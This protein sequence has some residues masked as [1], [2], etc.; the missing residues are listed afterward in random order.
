MI[1][2]EKRKTIYSLYQEGMQLAEISRRLRVS[3]NT[4]RAIVKQSGR[5]PNLPRKDKVKIDEELLR[6]LH[7]KCG[8]WLQRIHEKLVEEEG[9]QIGYSTLTRMIRELVLGQPIQQRCEHVPDEP[10]AEMQHDTSPYTLKIGDKQVRVIGSIL[11]FRYSKRRY[12]KFYRSFNRFK[13]KCFFHEA[14]T[15]FGY[16][17]PVCIIDNTNLARLRGTGKNAVMTSE[18][19]EFVEDLNHQAF[20]WATVRMANRPVS[21]TGLIPAKAFEHEQSYLIKLPAFVQS[22]YM[23]HKRGTDQYGYASFNGNFYWVPGTKRDDVTMLQFTDSLKIY[24]RRELLAEYHLPP[25]GIKNQPIY[26]EGMPKP[27]YK[28]EYRKKPTTEEEQKLRR[29]AAE[30]DAYLNF[31]LKPKGI[32]KHRFIRE[33]F[34]LYRKIALPIF[35]T[36]LKRA[37]KY[38]IT[39]MKTIER[40]AILLMTNGNYQIPHLQVDEQFQNRE[41]YLEGRLSEEV[42]L[43]VYDKIWEDKNG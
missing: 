28:P 35:I 42:D 16:T 14:L 23:I 20:D 8:G 1:D 37:L 29:A 25:D 32:Q 18:M 19:E 3:R 36:T 24:R 26:P 12:L 17:A 43:S 34:G 6:R 30:V 2:P 15:F 22:P 11:Y 40:I 21:Q 10:G 39:E 4:I 41:A 31:A 9:L 7:S 13:M 33:L 38:R 27:K 5:T